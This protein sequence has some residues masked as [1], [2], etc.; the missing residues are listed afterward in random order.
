MPK[1]R[2]S[3]LRDSGERVFGVIEGSERSSVIGRLGEQGLHPIEVTLA[4][5]A[6]GSSGSFW[7]LSSR[8]SRR[9][10]GLFAREL[11]W[12]LQAGM[13][14]N[15]GLDLLAQESFSTKFTAL[16]TE[17]RSEIRKGRSF[18]DALNGTGAFPQY[19][20][21]M[22]EVG[23]A[24]GTLPAALERVAQS[25]DRERRLNGKIVSALLYPAILVCLATVAIIFIMVSVVPSIKDMITSSGAPVPE[26]A[27]FVISV[28]DWL[29]ANGK[30]LAI[31][32]ALAILATY[33]LS[34]MVWFKVMLSAIADRI[35]FVGSLLRKSAVTQ[36][37]RTL[38]TLTAS[39]MNFADSLKLIGPST[40]NAGIAAA[41]NDMEKALR[42][43]D[44][45]IAPLEKAKVFPALLSRMLKV[46]NETGNL[47]SSILQVA[48]ILDEELERAIE[49]SLTLLGPLI[50]LTLSVFVAFI[51]T[52]LMSAIISIND[53]A[54]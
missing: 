3:A 34:G 15:D 38:G 49:R 18:R 40:P 47:T 9:E 1:F 54:L 21:S 27:Q 6:E 5:Q 12:L 52:S 28:S 46:G 31:I 7:S 4:D 26:S 50:I 25:L 33:L 14:L 41:V 35:P 43:G 36:F 23:E 30:L 51:I 53:L 2:Y 39:G 32:V 24:S 19:V 29:I 45:F 22:V 10:I 17:L 11:A 37:C 42:R 13:T 16:V 48:D 44:D 20:C 8:I